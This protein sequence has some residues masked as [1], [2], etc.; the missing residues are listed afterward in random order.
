M[1]YNLLQQQQI[2]LYIHQYQLYMLKELHILK[3]LRMGPGNA[4]A[5]RMLSSHGLPIGIGQSDGL[6]I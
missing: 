5:I 3:P 1:V 2:S 4:P 6:P